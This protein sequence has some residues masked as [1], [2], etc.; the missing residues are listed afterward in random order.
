[1]GAEFEPCSKLFYCGLISDHSTIAGLSRWG[2]FDLY[3]RP[4][5]S[6]VKSPLL[7]YHP[8]KRL[9]TL[10]LLLLFLWGKRGLRCLQMSLVSGALTA[11]TNFSMKFI[12]HENSFSWQSQSAGRSWIMWNTS[13]SADKRECR[14]GDMERK[15]NKSQLE[16]LF[17][18]KILRHCSSSCSSSLCVCPSRWIEPRDL[19]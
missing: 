1:M 12:S 8:P 19:L 6:F 15:R 11:G 5:H 18:W 16:R 4:L 14:G 13:S 2:S 3:T 10:L 7:S 17:F 9:M